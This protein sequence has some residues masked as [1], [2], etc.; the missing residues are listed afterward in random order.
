M[1][2]QFTKTVNLS[3]I[4][5]AKPMKRIIICS[6]W[7]A[8]L[9]LSCGES[10]PETTEYFDPSSLPEA[11]ARVELTVTDGDGF[12][13]GNIYEIIVNDRGEFA[14]SQPR[15]NQLL[16]FDR[17]G[18]FQQDLVHEGSGPGEIENLGFS[19]FQEDRLL[20]NDRGNNRLSWFD[21]TEDHT[22]TYEGGFVHERVDDP[23]LSGPHQ[24]FVLRDERIVTTYS[25]NFQMIEPEE[26]DP[27]YGI[28][29]LLD[30]DGQILDEE[31]FRYSF[32][33]HI[34]D[35]Q[36]GG[37]RVGPRPFRKASELQVSADGTIHYNWNEHLK[38]IR[39]TIG[40]PDTTEINL[41]LPAH[42]VTEADRAMALNQYDSE[43]AFYELASE[44]MP[45]T[46]PVVRNMMVD[47]SGRYWINLYR[48]EPPH[49]K[50]MVLD[51]QGEP[52]FRFY[53]P[54][55]FEAHAV[56]ENRLYGVQ[57]EG[58]PKVKIVGIEP[59]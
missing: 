9:T 6:L 43:S 54:E 5:K 39:F 45:E 42:E 4:M 41:E 48:Q 14:V 26:G 57:T 33:E 36:N 53:A 20:I 19:Q 15:E 27:D 51:F 23:N 17:E 24:L 3:I 7:V 8:L 22:Y 37:M 32:G 2:I 46:K 29:R 59:S 18:E 28:L 11:E 56:R 44:H 52:A 30:R 34:V 38:I 50:W 16:L 10:E 12:F 40:E 35:R 58:M 55:Q 13:F 31:V 49:N 1:K 25:P 47:E 21:R